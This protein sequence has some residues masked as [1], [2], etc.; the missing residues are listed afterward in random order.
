MSNALLDRINL[1]VS[2][3]RAKG[4]PADSGDIRAL[5]LM[6]EVILEGGVPGQREFELLDSHNP[7]KI[8]PKCMF[9]TPMRYCKKGLGLNGYC[10]SRSKWEKGE[11]GCSEYIGGTR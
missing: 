4:Y 2:S 5:D 11:E 10:Q 9:L 8:L 1:T 3:M 7:V 6:K